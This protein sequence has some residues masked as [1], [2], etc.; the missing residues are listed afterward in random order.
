MVTTALIT[1]GKKVRITQLINYYTGNPVGYYYKPLPRPLLGAPPCFFT[2]APAIVIRPLPLV[3]PV[4]SL[5]GYTFSPNF[6]YHWQ[7]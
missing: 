7:K 2:L 6:A 5:Q 3:Y 1:I 4:T